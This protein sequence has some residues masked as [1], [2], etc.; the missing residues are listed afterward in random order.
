VYVII[1]PSWRGGRADFGGAQDAAAAVWP[2]AVYSTMYVAHELCRPALPAPPRAACPKAKTMDQDSRETCLLDYWAQAVVR[3]LHLK[4]FGRPARRKTNDYAGP[5]ARK[6]DA[7]LL[8]YEKNRKRWPTMIDFTPELAAPFA[9]GH[10]APVCKLDDP[11]RAGEELYSKR[12]AE[13]L[14][15]KGEAPKK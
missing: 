1:G 5:W 6:L 2:E 12:R 3:R 8:K 15:M 11:E 9:A 7:A 13:W 4:T 10:R 14:Q